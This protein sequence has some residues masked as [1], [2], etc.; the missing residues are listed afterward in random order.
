MQEKLLLCVHV[1]RH[2]N[3]VDHIVGQA[4]RRSVLLRNFL[5][6]CLGGR[7]RRTDESII[8]TQ[9]SSSIRNCFLF[10]IAPIIMAIKIS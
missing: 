2:Q 4:K 9:E 6:S 1:R 3:R 10:F 5:M 8:V 7:L